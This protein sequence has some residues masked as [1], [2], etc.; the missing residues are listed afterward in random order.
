M[1]PV[2]SKAKAPSKFVQDMGA[3]G[4]EAVAKHAGDET[5]IG[6]INLPPGIDYGVAQLTQCYA[7]QYDSGTNKDKWYVRMVGNVMEPTEATSL[8]GGK[9]RVRG[10][11]TTLKVDLFDLK[12][13]DGTVWSD[14]DRQVDTLMNELRKLGGKDF[15]KDATLEDVESLCEQLV[16]AAPYFAFSTS[17]RIAQE[18]DPQK[19]IKKGQVTGA[20]ENWHGSEGL[21]DYSPEEVQAVVKD[22]TGPVPASSKNGHTPTANGT[23]PKPAVGKAPAPVPA[24]KEPEKPA[25]PPFVPEES[26]D[27]DMLAEV[28]KSDL[29][30]SESA[31]K[32][33]IALAVEAGIKESKAQNSDT[34]EQ[35]VGWIREASGGTP[36][37]EPAE[38]GLKVGD[39]VGF[40]PKNPV[41]KRKAKDPVRCEVIAVG[42]STV[43]LKS[44]KATYKAVSLDDLVEAPAE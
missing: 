30:I 28:A 22:N 14:F 35:V 10:L 4:A 43:D 11:Q 8:Q 39:W 20:W 23:A 34:W 6:F 18:D 33:L 36:E 19:G 24:K 44:G 31:G 7:A 38:E 21:E 12:K 16:A 29:D 41:T 26:T 3:K 13:R 42:D 32:R 5:R 25:D 40:H 1:P 15:T 17:P 9:M 37:P 27:L 2:S